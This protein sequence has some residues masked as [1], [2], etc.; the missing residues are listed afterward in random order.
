[1][2][3]GY[4]FGPARHGRVKPSLN[5]PLIELEALSGEIVDLY[6]D[7]ELLGVVLAV[8]VLICVFTS[9]SKD[10]Q[11]VIRLSGVRNYCVRQPENWEPIAR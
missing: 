2:L 5:M 1:M 8:D 7:H 4:C 11:T 10:R 6:N 9:V 3:V